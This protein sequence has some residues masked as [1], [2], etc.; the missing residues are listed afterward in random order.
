RRGDVE[1]GIDCH[2]PAGA[3]RNHCLAPPADPG[4]YLEASAVLP[5]RGNS[6]GGEYV[7]AGAGTPDGGAPCRLRGT[8]AGRGRRGLV[9]PRKG[10]LAGESDLYLPAMDDRR[11]SAGVVDSGAG[12]GGRDALPTAPR[13]RFAAAVPGLEPARP[14]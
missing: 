9:L 8:S 10:G 13:A 12:D 4:R 14:L 3:A 11:A 2:S 7:S 5:G 6:D 1:Q